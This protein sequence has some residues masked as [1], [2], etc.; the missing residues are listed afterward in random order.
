MRQLKMSENCYFQIINNLFQSNFNG[1]SNTGIDDLFHLEDAFH[2]THIVTEEKF[3]GAVLRMFLSEFFQHCRVVIANRGQF[4]LIFGVV[5]KDHIGTEFEVS[6]DNA[7]TDFFHGF[8]IPLFFRCKRLV[9]QITAPQRIF[10]GK[11]LFQHITGKMFCQPGITAFS[12]GRG[13][14]ILF[15]SD[16]QEVIGGNDHL[17]KLTAGNFFIVPQFHI[18]YCRVEGQSGRQSFAGKVTHRDQ[19]PVG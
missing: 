13:K 8:M 18:L 4:T 9:I 19:L 7:E 11:H 1:S 2:I 15:D 10:A 6:A 16:K 17:F 14:A 5:L 3:D 12:A